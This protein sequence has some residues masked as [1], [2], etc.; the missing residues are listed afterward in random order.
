MM[1]DDDLRPRCVQPENSCR[2]INRLLWLTAELFSYKRKCTCKNNNYGQG[3]PSLSF[4]FIFICT[5]AFTDNIA[6]LHYTCIVKQCYLANN[7]PNKT[8]FFH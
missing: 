5:D 8:A 3:L 2:S 7:K 1:I 4:E 6:A